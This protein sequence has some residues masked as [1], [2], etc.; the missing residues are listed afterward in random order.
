[1]GF[2]ANLTAKLGIDISQFNKGLKA[3]SAASTRFSK[4]V[5]KDFKTTAKSA[6]SASNSF[7][8][9]GKAADKGYKSVKRITQGIIVSQ[10]FYKFV[11]AIQGATK[12]LYGFSQAVEESRVAF[13]GL[14]RDADKA[15][16]FNNMLQDLAADTPFTYEQAADN[17]RML[18]AYEFKLQNMERIMRSIADATAA[19]GKTE[20][21]SN[22]SQALGQ[23]Q[24]K[25]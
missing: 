15:K 9:L 24:A 18:L 21:Y 11:H 13:T 16:R 8:I 19:S 23:I 25:G 12:K 17:A 22:I 20:S 3:A 6:T 14:I 1:M 10:A 7:K 4:Q 2:F 5:A